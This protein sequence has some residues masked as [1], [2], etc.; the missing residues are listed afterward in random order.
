VLGH[1]SLPTTRVLCKLH[2]VSLQSGQD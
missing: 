1:D 2:F